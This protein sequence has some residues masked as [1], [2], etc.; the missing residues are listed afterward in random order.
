MVGAT[1]VVDDGTVASLPP[2]LSLTVSSASSVVSCVVGTVTVKLVTPAGTVILPVAG[3]VAYAVAE[4]GFAVVVSGGGAD[5]EAGAG[6]ASLNDRLSPS[7]DTSFG[8][9]AM[10]S[11]VGAALSWCRWLFAADAQLG[12]RLVGSGVVGTVTVKLVTP[13]GTVILPVLAS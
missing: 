13:A 1:V 3:V 8:L 4:A 11:M 2:M 6:A 10:C 12:V 9:A 5:V 7:T